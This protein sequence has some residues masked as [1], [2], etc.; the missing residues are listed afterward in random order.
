MKKLKV[1]KETESKESLTKKQKSEIEKFVKKFV[2]EY[3][4]ALKMLANDEVSG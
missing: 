1:R 2:R 3:G 4:P